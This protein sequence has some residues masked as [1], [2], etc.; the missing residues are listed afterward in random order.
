MTNST[1]KSSAPK[2]RKEKAL[3]TLRSLT[4][5]TRI[6]VLS[7]MKEQKREKAQP[8]QSK[9]YSLLGIAG[10]RTVH[11]ETALIDEDRYA[12]NSSPDLTQRLLLVILATMVVSALLTM[13]IP[14]PL[15]EPAN[16]SVTSNPAKAPWYFLWLQELVADTTVRIGG[17]HA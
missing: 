10:T 7:A 14:A 9:T 11:V 17:W 5:S 15:E 1:Q 12:T 3:Q 8:V 13:V 2:T 16:P 4:P 6:A